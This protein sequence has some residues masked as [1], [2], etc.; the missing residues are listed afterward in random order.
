MED[1]NVCVSHSIQGVE[2]WV[3][4]QNEFHRRLKAFVSRDLALTNGMKLRSRE[5]IQMSIGP[6]DIIGDV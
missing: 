2:A 4:M 5:N 3:V 6:K 1:A